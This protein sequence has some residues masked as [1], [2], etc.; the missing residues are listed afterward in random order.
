[1]QSDE[2]AL[3]AQRG[4]QSLGENLN[5]IDR[6]QVPGRSGEISLSGGA[7]FADSGSNGP[8]LEVSTDTGETFTTETGRIVYRSGDDT[9]VLLE[10]GAVIRKDERADQGI[11]VQRPN[12]V[13]KGGANPY[14]VVSIVKLDADV[15]SIGGDGTVQI[16]GREQ[17]STLLY[18]DTASDVTVD[19]SGSDFQDAWSTHFDRTGDW[20]DT[21]GAAEC[22]FGG[23]DGH[24]IVRRTVIEIDFVS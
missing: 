15:N 10:N 21:G 17:S 19:Y 8:T 11:V 14:A 5:Q 18:S 9:R 22:D 4:F 6:R 3:N 12:V 2:Q 24:V 20:D 13:C 7:L 23:G 1:V 16:V